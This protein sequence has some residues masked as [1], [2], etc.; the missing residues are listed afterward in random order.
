MA[1]AP[2]SSG[3]GALEQ[4]VTVADVELAP[5]LGAEPIGADAEPPTDDCDDFEPL[6]PTHPLRGYFRAHRVAD[7]VSGHP[8]LLLNGTI[9]SERSSADATLERGS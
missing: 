4:E 1:T 6:A 3:L 2:R 5:V 7:L 9:S 8:D